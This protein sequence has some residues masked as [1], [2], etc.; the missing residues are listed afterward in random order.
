M[1]KITFYNLPKEKKRTLIEAARNEFS[2][3]PLYDASIANIVK[4]AGIPRGSFYQ[5]FENKEDAFFYLLNEYVKS[6]SLHFVQNL[7]R[8]NGDIFSAMLEFYPIIIEDE[9]NYSFLKNAFLNMS[10]KIER[11]FSK[12]VSSQD[13]EENM[14]EI[15]ILDRSKL[16]IENDKELS[17]VVQIILSVTFR[18]FVKK[19]AQDLTYE[20]AMNNYTTEMNLL[21]KGLSRPVDC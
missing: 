12:V 15:S 20:E 19:F 16:N 4:T 11:T 2:R 13:I 5:Y 18:N 1:P 21:K 17:H 9:A 7:K 6:L 3:V 14:K 8:H 10:Y